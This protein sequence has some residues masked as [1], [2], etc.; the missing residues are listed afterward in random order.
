MRFLTAESRHLVMVNYAVDPAILRPLIP[1]GTE[2]DLWKGTCYVSLV[3]FLFLRTRVL[4]IPIPFHCNFEEV[5]L[6]FYVRRKDG[7]EWKRGVAFIKEIVP[8]FAIA[9]V[10]RAVY[11]EKYISLPMR[12]QIVDGDR[13]PRSV[14]YSWR[15][16]GRWNRLRVETAGEWGPL[17]PGSEAEFIAEHYWG[18]SAQPDRGCVEYRVEHPPWNACAVSETIVDCDVGALYG[19]E[20]ESALRVQPVSAFLAEGSAVTVHRGERI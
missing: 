1:S 12:H 11:R 9:A 2:L 17:A 18:Y 6:R 14:E 20:F 3:G 5:N 8:R 15:L 10:A 7:Q 13:V 19:G 16:G 4:G